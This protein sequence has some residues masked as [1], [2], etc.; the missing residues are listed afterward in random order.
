MTQRTGKPVQAGVAGLG[1][2]GWNIHCRMMQTM[3]EQF[4][5]AAVFDVDASR[6]HEAEQELGCATHDTYDALLADEACEMIVVALPSHLHAEFAVRA[7]KAGRHVVVEKPMAVDT[8]EADAMIAAAKDAAGLL[9]VYQNR[10]YDPHYLKV[11]EIVR[12][13]VLGRIVEI[14]ANQSSFGRRWDWQTLKRYG[15]GQ[16]RNNGAHA[17]DQLLDLVGDVELEIFSHLDLTLALGDAEDH[18]KLILTGKG[19]PLVDLEMA[20]T[21]AYPQPRWLIMGTQGTL[22][23]TPTSIEW[24]YYDPA[25]LPP[26]ELSEQPVPDR[27]YNSDEI[28]FIE[29]AWELPKGASGGGDLF[30]ADLFRTIREGAPLGIT[31]ESVRR[32]IAIIE[33]CSR[34]SALY[35]D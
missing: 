1:R 13:G 3:P 11:R 22:M 21:C 16:L 18:V 7:L 34:R 4:N 2:S 29:E 27:G 6:R 19:A 28:T 30:Y 26:R 33:E 32:Q 20:A 12:S 15:G 24:K 8:A 35:T 23:G 25:T 10:R 14:K 5:V 9:T 17:L 31:P